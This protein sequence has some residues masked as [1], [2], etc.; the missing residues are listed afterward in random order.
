MY[1]KISLSVS[2]C[3][4]AGLFI[5]G[6]SQQQVNASQQTAGGQQIAGG[7]QAAGGQQVYAASS[8]ASGPGNPVLDGFGK[9][10]KDGFGGI[11]RDTFTSAANA[12]A[13]DAQPAPMVKPN[14]IDHQ[15][16]D[17]VVPHTPKPHHHKTKPT[18]TRHY[19]AKPVQKMAKPIQK[20][21]AYTD[22]SA[23]MP[24][25]KPNQCYAKVR[26]GPTFK[27]V[28]KRVQVSPAV[29]KRVLVR[30]PQYGYVSKRVLVHPPKHRYQYIPAQYKHVSKR[31]LVKPAHY[32]W[33]KG[34][35]GPVT[36]IDNMT[37]EIL[38]RVKIPA[39]YKTVVHKVVVRPAQ[40]IKQTIPAVYR[41]VKHKK[42][43][44][45]A[46]YKTIR[47]PARFTNKTYRIKTGGVGYKWKPINC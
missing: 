23:G 34:K 13:A 33:Q 1:K 15:V 22:Y 16:Q 14:A 36:R 21:V 10:V 25:A 12:N 39:V 19:M 31:V 17:A 18:Q 28:V 11:V 5:T 26:T 9:P 32:A 3:L 24:P 20:H 43:I 6:C 42:L 7:Q 29:N 4:L 35:R 8:S 40:R 30:G 45:P 38:C 41:T 46:Q 2:S 37:G 47:H 44:S 27:N